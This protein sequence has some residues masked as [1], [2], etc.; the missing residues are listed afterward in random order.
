MKNN[1]TDSEFSNRMIDAAIK[2][3]AI[4]LLILWCFNILS[5]FL[6]PIIWG[7]ILAIALFPI[8][9]KVSNLF[10]GNKKVTSILFSIVLI[11]ILVVPTIVFSASAIDSLQHISQELKGGTLSIPEPSENIKT[12]PLVGEQIHQ[13]W[14]SASQNFKGFVTQYPEQIKNTFSKVLSA[15][16]TFGGVILEFIIAIIIASVLMTKAESCRNVCHSILQRLLGDFATKSMATSTATIRSVAQGIL[17]IAFA[18][19]VLAGIGL[20][21]ADIPGAGIWVLLVLMLCIVQLPPLLIL[22]PIAAYYFTVAD[23]TL[24]ILFLIYSMVVSVSDAFLKPMFLGRGLDIPMLVILLGAIGGMILSGI[25]GL[26]IGAVV[27]ALGYQML[28]LWV[29]RST[30]TIDTATDTTSEKD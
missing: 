20:V 7:A 2:I 27:L 8:Y 10:N 13:G 11:S 14:L 26:F 5:P 6:L 22:G 15:A 1:L 29:E 17:G 19:A 21:I 25:I 23:P 4:G 3:V 16:A 12:W 28:T 9:N 30:T 18:Q 24:A